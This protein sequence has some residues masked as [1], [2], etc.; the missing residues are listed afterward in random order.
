MSSDVDVTRDASDAPNPEPEGE[1]N[2]KQTHAY[3][4]SQSS[5]DQREQVGHGYHRACAQGAPYGDL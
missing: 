2:E 4:V 5:F 1:A 3:S